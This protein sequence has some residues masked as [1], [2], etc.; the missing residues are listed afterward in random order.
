MTFR[1][2]GNWALLM[3]MMLLPKTDAGSALFPAIFHSVS[4][5][6]NA[7]FSIYPTICERAGQFPE[8]WS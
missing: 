4:A 6:C 5:F 8:S 3:W 2:R 7:G 1:D